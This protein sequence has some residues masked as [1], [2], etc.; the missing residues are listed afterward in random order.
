MKSEISAPE[1]PEEPC[2]TLLASGA[3]TRHG[4][5]RPAAGRAAS[6]RMDPGVLHSCFHSRFHGNNIR[7]EFAGSGLYCFSASKITPIPPAL[8]RMSFFFPLIFL[9]QLFAGEFPHGFAE[10]TVSAPSQHGV[11]WFGTLTAARLILPGSGSCSS[12][13]PAM[14]VTGRSGSWWPPTLE[15]LHQTPSWNHSLVAFWTP[16]AILPF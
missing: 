12:L 8:H 10:L 11:P 13:A 7:S 5:R 15:A 2:W 9:V 6:G 1:I 16:E 4:W 14:S 3:T